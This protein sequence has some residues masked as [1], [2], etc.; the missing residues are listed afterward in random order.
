ML[1]D[2]RTRTGVMKMYIFR[3]YLYII[4]KLS[5]LENGNVLYV[6][7]LYRDEKECAP[8]IN[9]RPY[10]GWSTTAERAIKSRDNR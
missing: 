5:Y 1:L 6:L 2:E 3:D 9:R 4:K 10:H 8:S 7:N